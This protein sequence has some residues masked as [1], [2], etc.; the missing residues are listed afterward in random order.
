MPYQCS[1]CDAVFEHLP[2]KAV[3]ANDSLRVTPL[4]AG[5]LK[6][7]HEGAERMRELRLKLADESEAVVVDLRTSDGERV[8]VRVPVESLSP[9]AQRRIK[10]GLE[11]FLGD[12][13]YVSVSAKLQQTRAR[14]LFT[15][16]T[17]VKLGLRLSPGV[18]AADLVTVLAAEGVEDDGSNDTEVFLAL[19]ILRVAERASIIELTN[20]AMLLVRRDNIASAQVNPP[21]LRIPQSILDA[22][23]EEP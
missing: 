22:V 19:D 4:P 23:A 21:S 2:P 8:P 17:P 12:G 15:F 1:V 6:A 3:P 13:S 18:A 11:K 20:A 5:T 14:R 9:Q 7:A 10:A 16:H